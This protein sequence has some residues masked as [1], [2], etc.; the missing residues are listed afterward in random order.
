MRAGDGKTDGGVAR[1]PG[2]P[3]EGGDGFTKT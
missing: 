2:I 1:T 3:Y